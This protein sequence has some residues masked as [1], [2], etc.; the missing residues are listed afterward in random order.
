MKNENRDFI[1]IPKAIFWT[2][3]ITVVTGLA[4]SFINTQIKFV[5]IEKEI[6]LVKID[7][8]G[9]LEVLKLEIEKDLLK[10]IDSKLGSINDKLTE[11][12][13]KLVTKQDK[14]YN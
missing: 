4:G 9:K 1:L 3:L 10:D 12:D 8:K 11:M 6:Q 14:K 7:M 13:K 5:H 2:F